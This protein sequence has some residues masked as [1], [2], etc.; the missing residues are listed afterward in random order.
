MKIW[1]A[2]S[3]LLQHASP[4][5]LLAPLVFGAGLSFG[6]TGHAAEMSFGVLNQQPP[7]ETAALWNPILSYLKD[8]T[9]IEFRL[10]MGATVQETDAM[11]ARGEFDFLYSNHIF[12]PEFSAANYRPI[13][14]WGGGALVGQVVVAA[15]SPIQSLKDL[16]GQKVAFPSRDAFVAYMVPNSA[17]KQANVKV[18][19]VFSASQ[20][21]AAVQ[22][23]SGR[24]AAASINK[25]FADKYQADGKGSFK[26]IYE[27]DPWP[28]LPVL[29]HPRIPK[30]QVD[31]VKTALLGF[32]QDPAA[33]PILAKLK[34]KGFAPVTDSEYDSTRRLY[35][36]QQ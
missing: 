27:S 12:D 31:A 22:L 13:A 32:A 23:S 29:A 5:K 35:R 28:N 8:K 21:G 3:S 19:A 11:S 10:K 6:I 36:E 2:P 25:M 7:T 20:Q 14:K 4:R 1:N 18:D 16:D 26:V 24:V 33:A 34:I 17:L 30:A 15:G 9:G